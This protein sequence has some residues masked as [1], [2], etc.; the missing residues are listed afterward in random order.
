[1]MKNSSL[2]KFFSPPSFADEDKNRQ[3]RLLY[4]LLLFCLIAALTVTVVIVLF[5][6][7]TP[8]IHRLPGVVAISIFFTIL[9]L[10]LRQGYV[11]GLSALMVAVL[12]VFSGLFSYTG[13]IHSPAYG[14][15]AV[16]ML[17][18]VLLLNSRLG[19]V[20]LLLSNAWG[21][22]LLVLEGSAMLPTLAPVTSANRWIS[23]SAI[24]AVL[25]TFAMLVVNN[26]RDALARL[27][28]K[29]AQ[30]ETQNADL[31]AAN[32][33]YKLISACN[34]A[35]IHSTDESQLMQRVCEI[36]IETGGYRSAWVGFVQH[37]TVKS[38]R[39]V[40]QA[41]YDTN[42]LSNILITWSDQ[43]PNGNGPFGMAIR[44]KQPQVLNDLSIA[45]SFRPW[46]EAALKYDYRSVIVLPLIDGMSTLGGLAIFSQN[47]GGFPPED[48][49]LL[50]EL[51]SDLAFGI[52]TMR[53]RAQTQEVTE[54]LVDLTAELDQRVAERT[55]ELDGFINTMPDYVYVIERESMRVRFCNDAF[56]K[57]CGYERRSDVEGKTIFSL[58]SGEL[59][60]YF[61]AQNE[62][63][64]DTGTPLHVL[65]KIA[66]PTG[67]IQVDT[68]KV[69]LRNAEN[70]IFA[71]LS[72]SHDL[73]E[74][75][76][77]RR[78]LTE[79]TMHLEA[80]IS[81][82]P[83]GTICVFDRDLR[84]VVAGG[85]A[86]E[87]LLRPRSDLEGKTLY[88]TFTAEI[89][90][91]LAALYHRALAGEFVSFESSYGGRFYHTLVQPI[92]DPDGAINNGL[93]I[94]RDISEQKESELALITALERE[95]ETNL[96]RNRLLSLLSHDF[97]SPLT[98][99][100]S[101][102]SMLET[103]YDRM[104]T[105]QRSQRFN[106]IQDSVRLLEAMLDDVLTLGRNDFNQLPPE[107]TL[108]P[109]SRLCAQI[110]AEYQPAVEQTHQLVFTSDSSDDDLF[111]ID[112]RHL[113]QIL[114]NLLSNAVKYSPK[115]DRV[116]VT[117]TVNSLGAELVVRDFGIGIPQE[118]QSHLF[119]LYWRAKNTGSIKGTGLGLYI[120]KQ[121]VDALGG[122]ITCE[123]V[124]GVGTTF[125]VWMPR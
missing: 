31:R 96:L 38:V 114:N 106:S 124:L 113:Y 80:I 59:A 47:V 10:L 42:Y 100:Q 29:E 90:E 98:V 55:A 117:L 20:I 28:G 74:L 95:R 68:H 50:D 43:S 18:A 35:L 77:M 37:D 32:R 19:L 112:D 2:M 13:G 85:E 60:A 56:A 45:E 101:A 69:P 120:I 97:R 54:A 78:E 44:S 86:L 17:L 70:Q 67:T 125:T 7:D 99:I 53:L 46:R 24:T 83:K 108:R 23:Q 65:E 27:R 49:T 123:S 72:I 89:A 62:A 26:L 16:A 3:A 4:V 22:V 94:I 52:S 75:L 115:A 6:S 84:F 103:Y 64:F 76:T 61:A 5:L 1:M 14:S 71:L 122:T 21:L 116:E 110:V 15:F 36:I 81:H 109:L 8:L 41:G 118:E 111:P 25:F 66:L 12:T 79:R 58:F 91:E 82:F 63:L 51:V 102:N 39:P 57:L 34:H 105:D 107:R 93:S 119:Q 48:V 9:L 92:F 33:R 40:A 88:E 104:T 73:T 30:L 87:T 121:A 11:Y